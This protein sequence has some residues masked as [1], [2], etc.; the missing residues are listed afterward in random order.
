[1]VAAERDAVRRCGC[2]TAVAL[3][4]RVAIRAVDGWAAIGE[5]ALL[6]VAR[7]LACVQCVCDLVVAPP[8]LSS[9]GRTMTV[10][11]NR[12]MRLFVGLL[13]WMFMYVAVDVPN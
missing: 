7:V 12:E 6:V 5:R 2:S 11:A 9:R 10:F 3:T 1:M 4:N 8:V 13:V